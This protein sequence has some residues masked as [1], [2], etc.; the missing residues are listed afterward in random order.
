M[1]RELKSKTAE[2]V[3]AESLTFL[4]KAIVAVNQRGEVAFKLHDLLISTIKQDLADQLI[5]VD[6]G[7][8]ANSKEEGF[9]IYAK[10]D[11]KSL[12]TVLAT[13]KDLGYIDDYP[14]APDELGT[15]KDSS[16]EDL[17]LKFN[18]EIMPDS[19]MRGIRY[20]DALIIEIALQ[21][22]EIPRG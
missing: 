22:K 9:R 5:R 6:Y 4:Q 19:F 18:G 3:R 13:L 12:G 7:G 15:F 10:K 2:E 20:K 1:N 11:A 17:R 21:K 14:K 8:I 16:G